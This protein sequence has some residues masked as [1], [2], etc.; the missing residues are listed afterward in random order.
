MPKTKPIGPSRPTRPIR[1][2]IAGPLRGVGPDVDQEANVRLAIDA[3]EAALQAGYDYY[4]PHLNVEHDRH[5]PRSGD[6]WVERD[7]VWLR[8]CDAVYVFSRSRQSELARRSRRPSY[9]ESRSS[10]RSKSWPL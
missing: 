10:I 1:V 4:L 7:L 5:Y 9:A 2:Y 3:A 6:Q 8:L